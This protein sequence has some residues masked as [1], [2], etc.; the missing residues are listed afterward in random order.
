MIYFLINASVK[1]K[2]GLVQIKESHTTAF[3]ISV[4]MSKIW[5][6]FIALDPVHHRRG[7]LPQISL[8][9]DSGLQFHLWIDSLIP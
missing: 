2:E 8:M 9:H 3:V 4:D 6:V 7:E 5:L 1:S